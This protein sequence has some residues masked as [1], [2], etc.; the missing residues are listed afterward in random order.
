MLLLFLAAAVHIGGELLYVSGSWGISIALMPDDAQGECQGAMAAGTASA[1]AL[2]P[3]LMTTLVV[4]WGSPGWLV[5]GALFIAAGWVALLVTRRA[6]GRRQTAPG[7]PGAV[8][9]D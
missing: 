3:L 2:G 4:G 7:E 6:P 5:L 8:P 9:A 1:Q